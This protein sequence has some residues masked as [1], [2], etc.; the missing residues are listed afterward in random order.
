MKCLSVTFYIET[1]T[2]SVR[3]A[4][5]VRDAIGYFEVYCSA[6]PR[7]FSFCAAILPIV[8][9]GVLPIVRWGFC[10]SSTGHQLLGKETARNV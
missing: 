9:L 7:A 2:L 8:F 6:I 4:M 1:N 5:C 3:V 10:P